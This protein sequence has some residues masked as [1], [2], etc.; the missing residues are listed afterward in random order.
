M[1]FQTSISVKPLPEPIDYNSKILLIGSC[2]T[3]HIGNSLE[4][5][6]FPVLQNPNGIL[7][8]PHSVCKS[9]VSYI[10]NKKF[11]EKDFFQLN[12]VWHSWEHH[13]RYSNINLQ[14]AVRVVN[15]SQGIAHEFLMKTD[16]LII[17]LGS[18]FSY[19]LTEQANKTERFFKT[20]LTENGVA[21]CH[22]APAQWFQ[23]HLMTIDEIISDFDDLLRRL[24]QFNSN[25]N[26]IF[27][28]SPVRHIRDGVVDNNHS[29]SRL[30][31]SVHHF[32][33]KYNRIFYF[34]A[35]ELV[36]D[37]LRDYR[38][39]DADLVHPN[40]MA[41]EFVLEKFSEACFSENTK[42]L[43]EEVKNIV[44]ARKHKAFQPKTKA[45]EQFLKTHFEKTKALKIKYPFLNLQEEINYFGNGSIL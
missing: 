22:R 20:A 44:I 39:Y 2:F 17:T 25:I 29:K 45:H 23:K 42:M 41:T 21:N 26:I 15:D 33:N 6:K 43:M 13:S 28:V 27:T 35:Y 19:R 32:V 31:E 18:S 30:I 16:W 1:E 5:L 14:E 10:E 3:E 8:D 37:V 36:I 38:F 12:E 9:L 40:Y 34:P 7:F 11:S 24:F 4:E